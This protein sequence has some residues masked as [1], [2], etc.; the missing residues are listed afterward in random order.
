MKN[1]KIALVGEEQEVLWEG[2]RIFL[3]QYGYEWAKKES[4]ADWL[5]TGNCIKEKKLRVKKS[6]RECSISYW[7]KAHF[8]LSLIH[9]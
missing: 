1:R 7:K 5:I 8:Y 6:G 2:M 9:I 3:E 4:E